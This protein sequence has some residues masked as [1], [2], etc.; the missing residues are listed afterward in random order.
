MQFPS[1]SCSEFASCRAVRSVTLSTWA[2]GR[3]CSAG[4]EN[5]P[6]RRGRKSVQERAA[7]A[8]RTKRKHR[9]APRSNRPHRCHSIDSWSQRD[10]AKSP[11][12]RAALTPPPEHNLNLHSTLVKHN[13]NITSSQH[14]QWRAARSAVTGKTWRPAS[15]ARS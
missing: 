3:H 10:V 2:R 7:A 13:T 4:V 14:N 15:S 8:A 12:R 1:M 9:R 5:R 11:P 6:K